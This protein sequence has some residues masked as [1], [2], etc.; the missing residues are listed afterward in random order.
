NVV[1]AVPN[2]PGTLVAGASELKALAKAVDSAWLRFALA[3][4]LLAPGED[5]HALLARSVV[6][7]HRTRECEQFA[8]N[9]DGEAAA[10]IAALARFR[11]FVA[12]ERDP[13]DGPPDAFHR[14]LERFAALRA[15][16]L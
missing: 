1:L 14:A 5:A 3:P 8:G 6:A 11:G 10:L 13:E 4:L 15:R 16:T 2:E 12:L 9:G 7:L